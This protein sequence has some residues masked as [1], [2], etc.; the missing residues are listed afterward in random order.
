MRAA[1]IAPPGSTPYHTQ[2]PPTPT[3]GTGTHIT[4][5]TPPPTQGISS[6]YNPALGPSSI[7]H[8]STAGTA[9]K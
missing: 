3:S 1:A 4:P 5:V 7:E 8:S 6:P 9:S 2:A